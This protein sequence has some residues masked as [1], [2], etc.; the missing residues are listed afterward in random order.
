MS[1]M[2]EVTALTSFATANFAMR[3][4]ETKLVSPQNA[5]EF[6][7]LGWVRRNGNDADTAKPDAKVETFSNTPVPQ[8]RRGRPG[9]H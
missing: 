8:K 4:T 7:R 3:E 5:E 2:I 1:T 6:T 9:K